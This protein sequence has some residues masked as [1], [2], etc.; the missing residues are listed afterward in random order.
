M[1][2]VIDVCN[3]TSDY[4]DREVGDVLT[5]VDSHLIVFGPGRRFDVTT[6]RPVDLGYASE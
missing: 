4:Y 6:R 5:V 1:V 3:A 2:T